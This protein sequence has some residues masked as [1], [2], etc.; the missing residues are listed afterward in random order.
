MLCELVPDFQLNPKGDR[1]P[2]SK[3]YALA[4]IFLVLATEQNRNTWNRMFFNTFK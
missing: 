4:A 2:V 1:A 3:P